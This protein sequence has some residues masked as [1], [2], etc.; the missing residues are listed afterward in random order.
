ML[1]TEQYRN[2]PKRSKR[3]RDGN[4]IGYD[5]IHREFFEYETEFVQSEPV[6]FNGDLDYFSISPEPISLEGNLYRAVSIHGER[7]GHFTYYPPMHEAPYEKLTRN[8]N[9]KRVKKDWGR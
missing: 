5:A 1:K 8:G 3:A 2:L 4:Y 6:Q 7:N 9:L